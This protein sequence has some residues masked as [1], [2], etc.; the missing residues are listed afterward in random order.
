MKSDISDEDFLVHILDN[1]S[2]NYKVQ[3]SKLE[4]R[5]SSTT[6]ALMIEDI[7]NELNLRY[8]HLKKTVED[9]S[10]GEK[11]L[12]TMNHFKGKCT[13]CGKLRHKGFQVLACK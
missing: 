2:I 10:N 13:H 6:N 1:L 12:M 7:Q 4:D 11:A 8:A 5:L 3:L 9:E